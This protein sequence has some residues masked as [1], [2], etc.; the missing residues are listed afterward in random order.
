MTF[1]L[2]QEAAKVDEIFDAVLS[3]DR[4]TCSK[5]TLDFLSL[6]ILSPMCSLNLPTYSESKSNIYALA[7]PEE[8]STFRM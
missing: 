4:S 5:L 8:K 2:T 7:I 1:L 6:L 3:E